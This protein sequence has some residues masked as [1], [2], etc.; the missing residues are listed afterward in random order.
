M[1]N[2]FF[3]LSLKGSIFEKCITA[4]IGLVGSDRRGIVCDGQF[5]MLSFLIQKK[6]N[7]PVEI[8]NRLVKHYGTRSLQ[9]AEIVNRNPAYSTRD[10]A[11]LRLVQNQP[12]LEA[13]VVFAVEQEYA[14]TAVDVMARRLGLAFIDVAS[15]RVA[16]PRVVEIMGKHMAWTHSKQMSELS[17]LYAFIDTCSV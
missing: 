16:S 12:F 5:G 13:E 2:T 1:I 9:I 4:S 17:K 8:A 7:F 14:V 10:G 3:I 11:P 6:Y 15:A